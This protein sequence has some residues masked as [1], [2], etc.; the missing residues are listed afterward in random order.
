M[1]RNFVL[2]INVQNNTNWDSYT[3]VAKVSAAR[4]HTCSPLTPFLPL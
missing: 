4:T 1:W 2:Y 3:V